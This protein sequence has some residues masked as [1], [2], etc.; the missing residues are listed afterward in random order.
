VLNQQNIFYIVKVRSWQQGKK[1]SR[2]QKVCH[3]IKYTL[4]D[5]LKIAVGQARVEPRA[6]F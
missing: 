1:T 2:Y 5:A 4:D 6:N 3:S